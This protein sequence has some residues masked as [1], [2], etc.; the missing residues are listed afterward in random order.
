[1][2]NV[3]VVLTLV[4]ESAQVCSAQRMSASSITLEPCPPLSSTS[5]ASPL[6]DLDL[7][8]ESIHRPRSRPIGHVTKA[9]TNTTTHF[10]RYMYMHVDWV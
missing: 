2:K 10:S 9:R 7:D 3:I 5:S 8:Q 6:E 1:M 4:T